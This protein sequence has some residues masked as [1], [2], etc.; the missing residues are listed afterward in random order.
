MCRALF[1]ALLLIHRL[2]LLP[3]FFSRFIFITLKYRILNSWLLIS[4]TGSMPDT[5]K[6][7]LRH[8]LYMH[9]TYRLRNTDNPVLYST[10][11]RSFTH[12]L[13]LPFYL[14]HG[15]ILPRSSVVKRR[16][17]RHHRCRRHHHL[18]KLWVLP[19]TKFREILF[20]FIHSQLVF[21]IRSLKTVIA[22]RPL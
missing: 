6:P 10:L 18:A 17:C 15:S 22:F 13:S 14:V 19:T 4:P 3:P 5:A 7:I 21:V 1:L 16:I 8:H 20:I 2:L 12:T 9:T 11:C